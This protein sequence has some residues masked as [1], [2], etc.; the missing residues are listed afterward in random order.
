MAS[1][2]QSQRQ[3]R[4]F[5]VVIRYSDGETSGNRVFK[6]EVTERAGNKLVDVIGIEP[7]T[8]CLQSRAGKTL[9]ALSGVAYTNC[10]RNFPLL[11]CPEVAPNQ[12]EGLRNVEEMISSK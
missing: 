10:Q 4:Y 6:D 12:G 7:A 11:N 2:Q 9:T 1:K 8:P 5:P 3:H